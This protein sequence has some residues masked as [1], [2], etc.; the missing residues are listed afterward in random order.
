MI[1]QRAPVMCR[2]HGIGL[3][4]SLSFFQWCCS[5]WTTCWS[6]TAERQHRIISS[7][8]GGGAG[9]EGSSPDQ[10]TTDSDPLA[11]WKDEVDS[12]SGSEARVLVLRDLRPRPH[13][14][15]R[16]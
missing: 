12:D 7:R 10:T 3:R 4:S 9:M 14:L 1:S 8:G 5:V 15:P 2:K 16:G 6:S 11:A 13:K